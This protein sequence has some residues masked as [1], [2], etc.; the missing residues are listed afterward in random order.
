MTQNL[1]R[2]LIFVS[3]LSVTACAGY[4]SQKVLPDDPMSEGQAAETE[5]DNSNVVTGLPSE[6]SLPAD[7][8]AKESILSKYNYL[9]PNREVPT[10]LLEKAVA[11]YDANLAK[12]AN[13][14]YLSVIDFSKK[15]SLKR[16]FI[17]DMKTGAV[18]AIHTAHGKGSDTN[19]D[20]YAEKF[21]NTSGSNMSSLGFYRA[22]EAYSG[23]HGLSM[24]LDGL[25]TTNSK[26]RARAIVVHAADYV[27]EKNVIQGRS[28]GCP[29]V[30]PENR[31][32]VIAMLKNGSIIYAGLSG[33]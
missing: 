8:A 24:R 11:Y 33:S 10:D 15:S 27:S 26:A 14:N 19:A 3:F 18:W 25:S 7:S 31:D 32:K 30:A 16:F 23:T 28:W 5:G 13:K 20:G 4:E 1:S 9:D 17:I 12:I 22:A 21:S 29:A 6:E 2:V